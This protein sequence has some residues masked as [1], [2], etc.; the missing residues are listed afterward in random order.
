MG[1]GPSALDRRRNV[2]DLSRRRAATFVYRF[3][4]SVPGIE[5]VSVHGS[6]STR[7]TE[8]HETFTVCTVERGAPVSYRCQGNR[9]ERSPRVGMLLG[10]DDLHAD[11]SPPGPSVYR[12]LRIE[13]HALARV[14]KA[15]GLPF[16]NRTVKERE[17]TSVMVN[18]LFLT[19][20]RA[21]ET[22]GESTRVA[23]LVDRCVAEI[24]RRCSTGAVGERTEIGHARE[25]IRVNLCEP[26]KLDGI[27]RAAGKSKWHLSTLFRNH[28]GI[29]PCKY[30]MHVRLARARA[31]LATG[32][33][34]SSVAS[35]AGFC[36]QSHF[37]RWFRSVYG[38]A[39]GQ[40]QEILLAG[41]DPR[42]QRGIR[43]SSRLTTS[44]ST[45]TTRA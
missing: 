29:S 22:D 43:S 27:A 18:D 9:H 10:P 24:V 14:A 12:I 33:S 40:Y 41:S 15:L 37:N 3:P 23:G 11:A 13:P 25:H 42:P 32:R 17:I 31:C 21:I 19:L 36:D 34:C 39:P 28:V 35:D 30:A 26:M 5:T 16:A 6:P 20:H 45:P 7:W 4:T 2:P 8:L 44:G 1:H 38:V